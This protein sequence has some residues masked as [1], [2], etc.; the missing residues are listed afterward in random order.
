M[1]ID[2]LGG[3]N[4]CKRQRSLFTSKSNLGSKGFNCAR[5]KFNNQIEKFFKKPDYS[6]AQ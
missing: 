5:K 3:R 2:H 6:D 4:R 1:K